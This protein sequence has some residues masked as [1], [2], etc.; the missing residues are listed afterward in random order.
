MVYITFDAERHSCELVEFYQSQGWLD[1]LRY[2][3]QAYD[4]AVN[5]I[6][7]D[8]TKEWP[9]PVRAFPSTYRQLQKL[10]FSWILEHIYWFS[11][12][13]AEI[14]PILTNVLGSKADMPNDASSDTV[15]SGKA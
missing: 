10:E 6:D 4:T 1:A 13:V 11:Y 7:A 12:T 3:V 9:N 2:L 5:R 15:A 14:D 8:P